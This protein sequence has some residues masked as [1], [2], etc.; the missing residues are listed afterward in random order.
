MVSRS[1]KRALLTR[2]A[3]RAE[4]HCQRDQAEGHGARAGHGAQCA[5]GKARKEGACEG[6]GA[7]LWGAWRPAQCRTGAL[8]LGFARGRR[9]SANA[10]L[11]DGG[12]HRRDAVVRVVAGAQPRCQAGADG[13]L[14]RLPFC[15]K[16]QFPPFLPTTTTSSLDSQVNQGVALDK[17]QGRQ[18]IDERSE[19]SSSRER[20]QGRRERYAT[21]EG[22]RRQVGG[23]A[24][25]DVSGQ[26]RGGYHVACFPAALDA[27]GAAAAAA[28]AQRDERLEAAAQP[29]AAAVS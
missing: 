17:V 1:P 14:P 29:A 23:T 25:E 3:D 6:V 5:S 26:A 21:G 12:T 19:R 27:G 8:G 22:E 28:A 11:G 7:P 16:A 18:G 20:G 4:S 13:E 24:R 9:N 10:P 2:A 15:C